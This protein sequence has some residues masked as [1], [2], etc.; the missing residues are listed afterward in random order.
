MLDLK[1]LTDSSY[2]YSAGKLIVFGMVAGVDRTESFSFVN[3]TST[4]FYFTSDQ[5]GG[6]DVTIVC[7][8]TG[9]LIRTARD[10]VEADVAVEALR[11]GD[12]VVTASGAHRPIRWI[13]HCRTRCDRHP[14]PRKVWPVRVAA[15]TF[16]TGLPYAELWLSPGHA[17]CL[18]NR[19]VPV[20][21]LL[22]GGRVA[23]VEQ[24]EVTYWHVE[25]DDHDVLIAN[26]M[27]A[28]SY[29]DTGNR[30]GF[31]NAHEAVDG[32]A[33]LLH[34]SEDA[35]PSYDGTGYC[36]PLVESGARL[37]A[38][39]ARHGLGR[40][41][42]PDASLLDP[43]V[44]ARVHLVADGV[45]V[46][47]A[48]AN[49]AELRF[50]VPAG[51]SELRLVTPSFAAKAPDVRRLGVIVSSLAV[52]D[53][54]GWQEI[55]L[56]DAGLFA[57]FHDVERDSGRTWRWTSG[58]AHLAASLWARQGSA[59]GQGGVVLRLTGRFSGLHASEERLALPDRRPAPAMTRPVTA[60]SIGARRPTRAVPPVQR[61]R[62]DDAEMAARVKRYL[63]R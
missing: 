24:A 5:A 28:E 48:L 59:M 14:E 46:A 37:S 32:A 58:E 20:R 55:A 38:I 62:Y 9:T 21:G 60:E 8:C 51:A 43:A 36:L 27:P 42:R 18:D 23:Q 17:L 57:G 56:D 25:L 22:D 50:L 44:A 49:A 16:G 40:A 61:E 1:G 10:G 52:S 35:A 45:V 6:T 33:T 13:G 39:R 54:A 7:F 3:P 53:G 4:E 34:F 26:G 47:P 41:A 29:L 15:D 30:R 63:A 12:M 19:L 11:V 2:L 31:S